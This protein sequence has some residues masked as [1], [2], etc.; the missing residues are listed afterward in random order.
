[1]RILGTLGHVSSSVP[2]GHSDTPLHR[3]SGGKQ[4]LV[5]TQSIS[6]DWQVAVRPA[7]ALVVKK[8]YICV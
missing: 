8:I 4:V 5:T 2:S 3:D 6:V 1:M 7:Y